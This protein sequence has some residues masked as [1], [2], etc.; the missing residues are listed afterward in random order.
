[1][2]KVVELVGGGSVTNG[3]YPVQLF[4]RYLLL[5]IRGFNTEAKDKKICSSASIQKRPLKL[6]LFPSEWEKGRIFSS[7]VFA[8]WTSFLLLPENLHNGSFPVITTLVRK[9]CEKNYS[10]TISICSPTNPG[11]KISV[12]LKGFRI[13]NN[14]CTPYQGF[15]SYGPVCLKKSRN[16]Q[17]FY[18]SQF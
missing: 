2:D 4:T 15:G 13:C 16:L 3:A 6:V 5:S 18:S 7:S 8:L 17:V 1:M 11:V 10:A 9:Q 14:I 12:S